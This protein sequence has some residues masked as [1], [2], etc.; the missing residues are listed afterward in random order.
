VVIE[1]LEPL[2][3]FIVV[4]IFGKLKFFLHK[5][6]MLISELA[7]PLAKVNYNTDNIFFK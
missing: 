1:W 5:V 2:T 6:R 4:P 3:E 7:G